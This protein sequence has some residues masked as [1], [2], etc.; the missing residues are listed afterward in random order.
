MK[1]TKDQALVEKFLNQL[2]KK[3]TSK[4]KKDI[5]F[6]IIY[7]SAAR[8]EFIKGVS[9]IDLLIQVL[10]DKKTE[11]VKKYATAAFWDLNK[12][13]KMN[14]E[15][16]CSKSKSKTLLV[17]ILR[18]IE[19]EAQ[20]Y[21]PLFVFGPNDL[22]W[23]NCRVKKKGLKFGA[24]IIF[25]QASVFINF[26]NEGKILYGRDIRKVIN[27]KMNLWEKFKVI[28]VPAYLA[29]L[30]I[31]TAAFV[32][33]KATGY[34]NKAILYE[35]NAALMYL[36]KLKKGTLKQREKQLKK[37]IEFHLD[38][39]YN[40]MNPKYFDIIEEALEHKRNGF[41]GGRLTAVSYAIRC[42]RFIALMNITVT[43]RRI[44]EA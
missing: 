8:G 42:F 2:V 29:A 43:L 23:K 16:S 22:D 27:P 25:P 6:I 17:R 24:N 33:D 7:G 26:K 37:L 36:D 21:T 28:T 9:D 41:K 31:L 30:G 19:E 14:F 35:V 38:I 10:S 12:K 20:L 11:H 5:D 13:Y 3:I 44:F 34:C 40:L 15:K 4:H 18:R 1:K 32:P 39:K